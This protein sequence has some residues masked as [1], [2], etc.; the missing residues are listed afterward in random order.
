MQDLTTGPITRHL[1]K[2]TSFMLVTMVFQTLYLIIDLYW[3]GKLGTQAVAAVALAGNWTFVV[4]S[5]SQMLGVG[6]TALVSHAVGAKDLDRGLLIFNQS[7]VL[8]SLTGLAFLIGGLLIA[9]PYA[10]SMGADPVTASYT[11][12]YLLWFVPAMALQFLLVA[13]GSALR[14]TGNFKPGMYVGAGSVI[15]NMILA[16]FLIFGWVTGRSFGVAGAAMAS[17]IAVAIAIVWMATYFR[18]QHTFLRI[19]TRTWRPRLDIWKRVLGIGMPTGFEFAMTAAQIMIVYAALRPFGAAAQAAYGVGARVVQALF[20]PTVALGFAVAPVA[21]QNFGARLADRVRATFKDA[22]W[23]AVAVMAVFAAFCTAFARP[24]ID[25]FTNDAEVLKI[26]SEY[27]RIVAINFVPSGITFVTS[28]MFQA[29]GYTLP[30][31][32]SSGLRLLMVAIPVLL[33]QRLPSFD[34]HWIWY[35]GVTAAFIQ[36]VISLFFLRQQFAQRLSFAE[37]QAPAVPAR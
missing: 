22:A 11:R 7:Q 33:L 17:L 14:A 36:M 3:V 26:G 4:M 19:D 2:T 20:M 16:P 6:T 8:A 35:I 12:N 29:M 24:L 5:L 9:T 31:L 34:L 25:I 30:S 15:I 1:L 23:M 32:I 21:G 13:M 27:L 18:A 37:T 10:N 28:S